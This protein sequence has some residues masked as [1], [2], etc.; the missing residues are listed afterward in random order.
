M[1]FSAVAPKSIVKGEYSVIDI[2]MYEEDFKSVVEEAIANVENEVKETKSGK[3][4]AR[5][6]SSIKVVLSSP[7]LIIED[8][9]EEQV[10]HGEYLDFS[11]AVEL[12]EDYQK[13][14]ILF[15]ARDRQKRCVISLL[16]KI[17]L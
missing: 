15:V 4:R 13:R 14:Q 6:E 17:S 1:F 8:N 5:K 11:Y 9:T 10:W 7:D 16:V 2:F 3:M 12:P